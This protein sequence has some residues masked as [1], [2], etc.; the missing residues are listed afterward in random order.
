MTQR[1]ASSFILSTL[2]R[3]SSCRGVTKSPIA[4]ASAFEEPA[5]AVGCGAAGAVDQASE[6][7]GEALVEGVE[8]SGRTIA[9]Y[10]SA[11]FFDGH[12]PKSCR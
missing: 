11:V 1:N 4:T 8:E 12:Q 3:F 5:T 7:F 9:Q 10:D 6:L 2:Q